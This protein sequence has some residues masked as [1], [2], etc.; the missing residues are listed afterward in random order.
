M[1]VSF[2]MSKTGNPPEPAHRPTGKH[3]SPKTV[4]M[5]PEVVACRE[6]HCDRRQQDPRCGYYFL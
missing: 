4:R 2:S 6:K 3:D 5:H 1:A